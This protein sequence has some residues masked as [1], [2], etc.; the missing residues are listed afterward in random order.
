MRR[1]RAAG[2]HRPGDTIV[3]RLG[4]AVDAAAVDDAWTP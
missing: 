4:A 1:W 2:V 3:D